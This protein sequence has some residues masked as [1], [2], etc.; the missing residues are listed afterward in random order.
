MLLNIIIVNQL[1]FKA[2]SKAPMKFTV[3]VQSILIQVFS[4]PCNF[5][6]KI[7]KLLETGK[8]AIFWAVFAKHTHC[9]MTFFLIYVKLVVKIHMV[10]FTAEDVLLCVDHPLVH[11]E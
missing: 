9:K 7:F 8:L 5:S 11:F 10:T 3:K 1:R 2:F 6:K 4:N